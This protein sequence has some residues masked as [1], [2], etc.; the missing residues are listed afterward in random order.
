MQIQSAYD[1]VILSTCYDGEHNGQQGRIKISHRFNQEGRIDFVEL[2]FLRSL[3]PFLNG[4]LRKL[5]SV[6]NY[7][8]L[9]RDWSSAEAFVLAVLPRELIFL[10]RRFSD[11]NDRRCWPGSSTLVITWW[12]ISL[13]TWLIGQFSVRTVGLPNFRHNCHSM[14]SAWIPSPFLF[15][16]RLRPSNLRL[17]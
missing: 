17:T 5:V 15:C 10:L 13:L 4:A 14:K 11:A 2:K 12:V 7:Q 6:C 1:H 3:Q 9:K 16:K 8:H